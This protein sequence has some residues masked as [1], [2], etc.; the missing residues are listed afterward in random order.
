VEDTV[1]GHRIILRFDPVTGSVRVEEADS[2]L[3]WAYAFWFA[4][5]AFY[6]QTD[7]WGP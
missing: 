4:W 5:F 1:R 2:Q 7:V 6:P 3:R